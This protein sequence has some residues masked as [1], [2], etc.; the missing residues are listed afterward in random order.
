MNGYI[1]TQPFPKISDLE[2]PLDIFGSIS[3]HC[4]GGKIGP[5]RGQVLHGPGNQK[6]EHEDEE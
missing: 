1:Q 5:V 3:L 4:T 6:H 2:R